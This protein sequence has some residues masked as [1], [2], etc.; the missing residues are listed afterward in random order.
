MIL[1]SLFHWL[2]NSTS[3]SSRPVW[4]KAAVLNCDSSKS[5][6]FCFLLK[7]QE[8]PLVQHLPL[9]KALRERERERETERQST[10]V[11]IMREMK[12]GEEESKHFLWFVFGVLMADSMKVVAGQSETA[13]NPKSSASWQTAPLP[14]LDISC[15]EMLRCLFAC[16][17]VNR[18]N[19][20]RGVRTASGCTQPVAGFELK[21]TEAPCCHAHDPVITRWFH[22]I[23]IV[24]VWMQLRWC[25][26][27]PRSLR[28]PS[29]WLLRVTP[30]DQLCRIHPSYGSIQCTSKSSFRHA[31]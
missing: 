20:A 12:R 22:R 9:S 15:S 26:L 27:L 21:R 29:S 13:G 18:S 30:Q 2:D 3:G 16:L 8:M 10:A 25:N 14:C 24:W 11:K 19:S 31:S 28:C 7:V 4:L 6:R 5:Q 1:D 17:F 23:A